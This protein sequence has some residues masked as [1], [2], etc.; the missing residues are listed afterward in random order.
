MGVHDTYGKGLLQRVLG[1]RFDNWAPART[2]VLGSISITL[3][4]VITESGSSRIL[5]AVEIEAENETQVRGA[6]MNLALHPAPKALLLQMSSNLNKPLPQV[7]AHLQEVWKRLTGGARGD[8][9]IVVLSG[10][11]K[12]PRREE[13]EERLRQELARLAIV[14]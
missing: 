7:I 10:D 8:L 1:P 14:G 2:V 5:C 4:G 11:G 13:D 9:P 3:D 6:V 12:S